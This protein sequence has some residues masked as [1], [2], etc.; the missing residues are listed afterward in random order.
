MYE[1]SPEQFHSSQTHHSCWLH[2]L[3]KWILDLAGELTILPHSS[4][5]LA[6]TLTKDSGTERNS[7]SKLQLTKRKFLE[8]LLIQ[9]PADTF[10][11]F[12]FRFSKLKGKLPIS[13]SI[14][15]HC[16]SDLW[17]K[18]IT[19]FSTKETDTSQSQSK[20]KV[21]EFYLFKTNNLLVSKTT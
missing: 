19:R 2:V 13:I 20:E 9:Y 3:R 7:S 6:R 16:N 18:G 14:S 1:K 4:H 8:G 5:A 11:N 15:V 21:P 17:G 12:T 10:C